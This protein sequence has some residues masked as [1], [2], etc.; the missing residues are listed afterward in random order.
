MS[1]LLFSLFLS[2]PP[3]VDGAGRLSGGGSHRTEI[4]LRKADVL[5]GV[6]DQRGI[7]LVVR[8]LDPAGA[9]LLT[10]DSPN[11]DT[12]PEPVL[13]VAASAGRHVVE[14]RP[15]RADAAEGAFSIHLEARPAARRDREE[16]EA[17]GA[18][19]R[20]WEERGIG[21]RGEPGARVHYQ[22]AL[23]AGERS[24]RLRRRLHGPRHLEVADTLDVLGYIH[25]ELGDYRAG[26]DA[27]VESLSIRDEKAP[28][29]GR[30]RETRSDLGWLRLMSGDPAGARREFQ[31]VLAVE[32]T[33]QGSVQ[34]LARALQD[35]GDLEAA[36]EKARASQGVGHL[37][38]EIEMAL[39]HPDEAHRMVHEAE[40]RLPAPPAAVRVGH[41]HVL[42]VLADVALARQDAAVAAGHLA[43]ARAAREAAFGPE[44]PSLVRTSTL[45]GRRRAL[46]GDAAGAA[47]ILREAVA[48]GERTLGRSHLGLA[49]TLEALAAVESARGDRCAAEAA[50][51]RSIAIREKV[52]LPTHPDLR[53][54]RAALDALRAPARS[55]PPA[56]APPR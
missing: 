33:R 22:R 36:R 24:L 37:K 51:V 8:V 25:D 55:S 50:L 45:E 42:E 56:S 29:D 21:L 2:A 41:A 32:P 40:Q 49:P 11:G 44:H 35:L 23:E 10:I 6:V 31:A 13:L 4:E 5:R 30:T 20:A 9:G 17:L 34:G 53:R 19:A 28:P 46:A 38:A 18:W 12:G 43:R 27:F 39:G 16:A 14:L 3:A 48:L 54:A 7:D 47:S 1:V 52:V 26:L 15:L